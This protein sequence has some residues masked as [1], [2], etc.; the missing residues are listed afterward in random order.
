[1]V[2]LGL[3]DVTKVYPDGTLAVDR[4][5]LE[6]DQGE[7]LVLLGPSGCG[8]STVLRM[9][10]GLEEISSG[11][12]RI[13]HRLAN[14]I[15]PAQRDIAMVFQSS[16]LYPH[17]SVRDNLG[18][19][20]RMAKLP[21]DDVQRR[22]T[23]VAD[24]LGL[25]G[26]LDRMPSRLSGGERQ[27]VAMGR[28]IVRRPALF[29]MD[30][31]LSNL[32]AQLRV[33]LRAE[34]STLTRDLGTTTI[35]VTHDQAEAMSMGH[36]IAIMR[37]GVLQQVGTGQ[38]VYDEPA[39]VFVATF[40]GSPR[41]NLLEGRVEA[42]RDGGLQVDLGTQKLS[43]P[44]PLMPDHAMLRGLDGR[45]VI[46]GLRPDA[47]TL[48]GRTAHDT[49]YARLSAHIR[50]VEFLGN[51]TLLHLDTGSRPAQVP[52]L[53]APADTHLVHEDPRTDAARRGRRQGPVFRR[54][55]GRSGNG[56]PAPAAA[57]GQ[58]PGPVGAPPPL[59]GQGPVTG[60][61]V[62]RLPASQ[63]P[64]AGEITAVDVELEHLYVF[65]FDGRRLCPF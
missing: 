36:R 2:S 35:Y 60:D 10:A 50:H 54:R 30:E 15:P 64:R 63:H 46:V 51:E 33:H 53:A 20:L 41:M 1:M 31:P 4:L 34:I 21:A 40:I 24:G 44:Q 14:D 59:P 52:D 49:P 48:A 29:L 11:E 58:G 5:S 55:R 62:A 65:G 37:N 27:R 16:A 12:L 47:I 32:D 28:A 6:V 13:G 38:R 43:F 3:R 39:N 57:A 17:F 7:F 18:F 25:A 8:K 42:Q 22:V 61:L 26:Y 23:E 19:A 56:S 9:V 45:Y